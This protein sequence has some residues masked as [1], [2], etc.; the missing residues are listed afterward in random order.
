MPGMSGLKKDMP[1]ILPVDLVQTEGVLAPLPAVPAHTK[2][3]SA[4]SAHE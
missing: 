1:E 3:L 2:I 4:R